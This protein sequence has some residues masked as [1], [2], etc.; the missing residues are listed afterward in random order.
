MD[1]PTSPAASTRIRNRLRRLPTWLRAVTALLLT[2][3][4]AGGLA[5]LLTPDDLGKGEFML[6]IAIVH[7]AFGFAYGDWSAAAGS[8]LW[9]PLGLIVIDESDLT[10]RLAAAVFLAVTLGVLVAAGAGVRKLLRRGARWRSFEER[11]NQEPGALALSP[12]IAIGLGLAASMWVAD[13]LTGSPLIV[14]VVAAA[15]WFG[16]QAAGPRGR[17]AGARG[18]HECIPPMWTGRPWKRWVMTLVLVCGVLGIYLLLAEL[19]ASLGMSEDDSAN[20]PAFGSAT[21]WAL[22][23]LLY[24]SH[25]AP[26]VARRRMRA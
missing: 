3:L 1:A 6:G 25:I 2:L 20:G 15:G 24:V 5:A 4:F 12:S 13:A 19:A 14:L 10:S 9:F 8:L 21:V 23:L 18:L 26:R 22:A 7:L 16:A 11:S 17:D